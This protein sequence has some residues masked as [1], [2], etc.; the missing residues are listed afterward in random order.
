MPSTAAAASW[1]SLQL[2]LQIAGAES[3]YEWID[4]EVRGQGTGDQL[5]A[6]VPGKSARCAI[7]GFLNARETS[8]ERMTTYSGDY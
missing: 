2:D 7:C 6:N 5:Y 1:P 4:E 8:D 3:V